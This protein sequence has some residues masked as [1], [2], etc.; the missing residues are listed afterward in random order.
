MAHSKPV[1]QAENDFACP[2]TRS[3]EH[4]RNSSVT[5]HHHAGVIHMRSTPPPQALLPEL[6][7]TS[8][9]ETPTKDLTAPYRQSLGP[10][11]NDSHPPTSYLATTP[12]RPGLEDPESISSSK[13]R[14]LQTRRLPGDPRFGPLTTTCCLCMYACICICICSPFPTLSLFA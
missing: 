2:R 7:G 4:E 12:L 9:V 11:N 8:M 5:P 6:A 3:S 13:R 14:T 10:H 1:A